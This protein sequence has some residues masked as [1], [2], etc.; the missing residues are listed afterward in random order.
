MDAGFSRSA[1][2]SCF[3]ILLGI[4]VI[5]YLKPLTGTHCQQNGLSYSHSLVLCNCF[6]GYFG[7]TNGCGRALGRSLILYCATIWVSLPRC[8]AAIALLTLCTVDFVQDVS[9]CGEIPWIAY[10]FHCGSYCLYVIGRMGKSIIGCNSIYDWFYT[11]RGQAR[12]VS[13]CSSATLT[14]KRIH[15]LTVPL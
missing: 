12:S 11:P 7:Y 4:Y 3:Q 9:N 1:R 5:K 8:W 13:F 14:Q 15:P 6:G 10:Y 2:F